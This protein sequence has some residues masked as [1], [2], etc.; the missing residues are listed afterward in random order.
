M[1]QQKRKSLYEIKSYIFTR[2]VL[3]SKELNFS[4]HVTVT[5]YIA[6]LKIDWVRERIKLILEMYEQL[7]SKTKTKD[8]LYRKCNLCLNLFYG[9]L[10]RHWKCCK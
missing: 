1:R 8:S 9:G 7:G 3:K 4:E 2:Q 10:A 5:R 6:T